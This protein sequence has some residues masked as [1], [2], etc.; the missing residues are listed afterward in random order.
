[1]PFIDSEK[2]KA[3]RREWYK[4]NK[5]SEKKHVKNRKT[6]IRK[7]INHYKKTL[8]CSL[9]QENHPATIDFHHIKGKDFE[10]GYMVSNGYSINRIKSELEKCQILCANCHRKEHYK[11]DNL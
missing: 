10:I 11:K 9:C 8:T 6:E 5:D 4:N 1:M 3:Y 7:W 2:R